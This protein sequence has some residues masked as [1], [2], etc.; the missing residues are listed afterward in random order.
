MKS[1]ELLSN[2]VKEEGTAYKVAKNTGISEQ[3]LS[4]IKNGRRKFSHNDLMLLVKLEKISFGLASKVFFSDKFIKKDD[5]KYI[6]GFGLLFPA[7]QTLSQILSETASYC[8]LCK[9][10]LTPQY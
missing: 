4:N 6:T 8:I 7:M 2:L 9:I 3:K 5:L 1:K 10:R